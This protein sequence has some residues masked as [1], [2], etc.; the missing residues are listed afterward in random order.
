MRELLREGWQGVRA[1]QVRSFLSALGILFGVAAI[2]AILGIGEGARQE[3]ER[4]IGQLGILN[5]IVRTVEFPPDAKEAKEEAR[6]VSVGLSLRDVRALR[7]S[8]PSARSVG[9]MRVLRTP[10]IVPRLPEGEQV[11]VLGADPDYL[12][13]SRLRLV[14][15]RGL[16]AQDE[17][18]AAAVCLLGPTAR[19]HLFGGRPAIGAWVRVGAVWLRVVGVVV[20]PGF[21]GARPSAS[22][23]PDRRDRDII[24]PLNTALT[25]FD[26][27]PSEPEL[28]ELVVTVGSTAEVEGHAAV[29]TRAL[30]RLHRSAADTTVVVPQRLLQQSQA[31]QRIFNVFMAMIAGISLLVGGIGIM[32]ILLASVME[33]TREIGIRLAVGATPRDIQGL[34]L[35]ESALISLLGGGLG[36][37]AGL[38]LT[39]AVGRLTG[40]ATAASPQAVLFAAGLSMLEGLIFGWI[41]ARQA[42]RMS[43][44]VAV[45]HNG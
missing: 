8:L 37:V 35:A 41:P 31:Q 39:V 14:A 45:R 10:D 28:T 22:G 34:F 5:L 29:T 32:N 2:I 44:A 43:P 26:Q 3:Q 1:H 21:G 25:R 12:A 30:D 20:E 16:D 24:V 18:R 19:T 13:S 27:D 9:G 38:L 42:S 7:A 15:G 23:D 6:R 36:I 4:L 33:R 40:W 11:R 17:A